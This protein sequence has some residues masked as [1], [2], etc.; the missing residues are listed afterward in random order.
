[1]DEAVVRIVMEG[2]SGGTSQAGSAS[3]SF[4]LSSDQL[5]EQRKTNRILDTLSKQMVNPPSSLGG[6]AISQLGYSFDKQIKT[7][8]KIS[9]S[10]EESR[11]L[12]SIINAREESTKRSSISADNIIKTI[13][14][15]LPTLIG[16]YIGSHIRQIIEMVGAV[17]QSA[18][19][20]ASTLIKSELVLHASIARMT[21][22][23][24]S[25][26]YEQIGAGGIIGGG[27]GLGLAILFN[28]LMS[29]KEEEKEEL[30]KVEVD[31]FPTL[32]NLTTKIKD[33]IGSI[34]DLVSELVGIS[35]GS[36]GY[37]ARNLS[38]DQSKA[39]SLLSM[40]TVQSQPV[41]NIPLEY[42]HAIPVQMRPPFAIPMGYP[43]AIPDDKDVTG[44]IEWEKEW[45]SDPYE[46]LSHT[47]L[48]PD[49]TAGYPQAIPHNA[50]PST[51]LDIDNLPHAEP[52][53][54]DGE[55][56]TDKN[57]PV[58]LPNTVGN[59]LPSE[60][61]WQRLIELDVVREG[62]RRRKLFPKERKRYRSLGE[63][64]GFARGGKVSGSSGVDT[65]PA[66]LTEGEV[67]IPKEMVEGGAVDHLRGQLP[68]FSTGGYVRMAKGGSSKGGWGTAAINFL[69]GAATGAINYATR[70]V[71]DT[72]PTAKIGQFGDVVS[73]AGQALTAIN[74]AVGA[75]VQGFGE[76]AKATSAL[77]SEI[78][79]TAEKYGQYSPQI[80]T[81][82]AIAE[83]R[84]TM[85]DMRRANQVGGELAKYIKAKTDA[86]QAFEE[87]KIRILTAI[88]PSV[89]SLLEM[90]STLVS[91]NEGGL[92]LFEEYMKTQNEALKFLAELV[93]MQKQKQLFEVGDP[94][95]AILGQR[96]FVD[97]MA[98]T[99]NDRDRP[100][101]TV[102][103]L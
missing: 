83:I 50:L 53:T 2:G 67:V 97:S 86:E 24:A 65:I 81:A 98:I 71:G 63:D 38:L 95:D 69:S 42:P 9:A 102:P 66:L 13:E 58:P 7:L 101:G 16:A 91:M 70:S 33:E 44:P 57:I 92:F 76:I 14:Y 89:T 96:R 17:G 21:V 60:E 99:Q 11:R 80:A 82:Q 25:T 6:S 30:L 64:L 87:T 93:G 72:D 73:K 39:D 77:M 78:D 51:R 27:I 79:K 62:A 35:L 49:T 5:S 59:K 90:T 18:A 10:V 23:A 56:T 19:G 100:G 75:V 4:A 68:G 48:D 28:K 3:S 20:V 8:E 29:K 55:K 15:G 26:M 46:P 31:T 32:L 1:M 37:Q 74:P 40:E 54:P 45:G 12:L 22:E 43:Q 41:P 94:T 103:D 36:V 84:T 88:L 47:K 34:R 61:A 85:G 52:Y